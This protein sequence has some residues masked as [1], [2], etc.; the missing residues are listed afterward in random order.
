MSLNNPSLW[1][2]AKK[3]FCYK[4]LSYKSAFQALIVVQIIA[5]FFSVLGVGNASTRLGGMDVNINYLS[6]D[7]VF[8]FTMLWAF[9]MSLSVDNSQ[10]RLADQI[11]I[12]NQWSR[13]L[14]NAMFLG[15]LYL[16]AAVTAILSGFLIKLVN[17]WMYGLD[18]AVVYIDYTFWDI[19]LAIVM[20]YFYYMLI[21]SIGYVIGHFTMINK[22]MKIVVIVLGFAFLLYQEN[23][24]IADIALFYGNESNIFLF[25]L[26]VML[27][28]VP[29]YMLG[30]LVSRGLEAKLWN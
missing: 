16:L 13:H 6:G 24:L 30:M 5:M 11:F 20:S 28:S 12:T 9:F 10:N 7:I 8:F 22:V 27:T 2:V 18:E 29:I 21:G 3:Q 4:W 17:I 26:K 23:K 15:A 19:I 25:M 14:A 1:S